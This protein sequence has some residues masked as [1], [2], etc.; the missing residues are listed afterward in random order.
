MSKDFTYKVEGQFTGDGG[1]FTLLDAFARWGFD[2]GNSMVIG[3]WQNPLWRE[4]SLSP[5]GMLA[6]DYSIVTAVYAPGYT[7]G[8]GWNY[9]SDSFNAMLSANDGLNSGNTAYTTPGAQLGG[10]GGAGVLGTNE[11]DIGLSGRFE[12]KGG[13]DW[14]AFDDF[15]GWRGQDTAWLIGVGA[16]WEKDG[17]TSS[18]GTSFQGQQ[19]RLA[20]D[21]M[22]EGNGW[23]IYALALWA[24]TDPDSGSASIDDFAGVLQGGFMFTDNWEG[25]AGWSG[26]FAD[27]DWGTSQDKDFHTLM[28]GV[29]YYPFAKSG[30]VKFTADLQWFLSKTSETAPVNAVASGP[31]PVGIIASSEDNQV[32]LR[33]QLQVAF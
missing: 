9:K 28:G 12:F 31:N 13:G 15:T 20:V 33:L 26:I 2:S 5:K 1:E 19:I 21:G 17:N 8:I 6:A 25:F 7:Q 32:A 27:K 10:P 23:N 29:N 18:S 11:A 30:A 22:V 16:H 4:W 14:K 3:Q 24:R